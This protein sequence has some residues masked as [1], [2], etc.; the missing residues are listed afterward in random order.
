[1]AAC[2]IEVCTAVVDKLVVVGFAVVVGLFAQQTAAHVHQEAGAVG[3]LFA[4]AGWADH[5][6]VVGWADYTAV[7]W[8]DYTAAVG[9]LVVTSIVHLI[10]AENFATVAAQLT[11]YS[12]A[13]RPEAFAVGS[14]KMDLEPRAVAAMASD[15]HG[16]AGNSAA[17]VVK[18]VVVA[19]SVALFAFPEVAAIVLL[20]RLAL[21]LQ[22]AQP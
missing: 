4:V 8:A 22:W 6:A 17:Q 14:R 16:V 15:H 2:C 12:A 21:V 19:L 3:V 9:E 10:V 5:T 1:V 18:A 13:E 11:L 20:G 7:G